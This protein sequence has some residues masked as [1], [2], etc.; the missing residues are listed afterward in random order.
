MQ[1]DAQEANKKEIGFLREFFTALAYQIWFPIIMY[2]WI[3]PA[4]FPMYDPR[5]GGKMEPLTWYD[6]LLTLFYGLC[7]LSFF[8]TLLIF[9]K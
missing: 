7:A 8:G 9:L 3:V 4:L 1:Q 6:F 2:F 5:T